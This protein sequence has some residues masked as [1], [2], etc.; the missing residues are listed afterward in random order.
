VDASQSLF[1]KAR[2]GCNAVYSVRKFVGVPDG[3]FLVS[4]LAA[5]RPLAANELESISRCQHLLARLSGDTARGYTLFQE[6]EASLECCEPIAMSQLT[7]Q[8]ISSIDFE[9]LAERR[10]ANYTQIGQ[11]LAARGLEIMPLNAGAVPLCCPVLDVDAPALRKKLAENHV[12]TASYWPSIFLPEEDTA[13]LSLRD[14]TVF[15]PCDQRLDA[16]SIEKMIRL[17]MEAIHSR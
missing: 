13:A 3:G 4:E 17:L 10:L 6:A 12:F 9:D 11:A 5:D 16:C 7:K 1:F 14:R 8:L 2:P 15:L